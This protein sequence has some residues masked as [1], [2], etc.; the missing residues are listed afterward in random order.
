MTTTK[1]DYAILAAF[2]ASYLGF[3]YSYQTVPRY[4]LIA[5][6][7]FAIFYVIWGIFHHLKAH[8]FHKRIVLEYLL[9]ALL[10]LAIVSTL[11]L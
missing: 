7:V 6:S 11:L 8:N 9:V 5:T 10:G 2:S 3:V 4:I 1:L